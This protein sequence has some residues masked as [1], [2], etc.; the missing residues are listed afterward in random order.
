MTGLWVSAITAES[1]SSLTVDTAI[2]G[3][4]MNFPVADL[5]AVDR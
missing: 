5:R 1:E 3:T 4:T 2:I